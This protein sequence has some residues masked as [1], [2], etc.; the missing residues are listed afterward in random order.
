MHRETLHALVRELVS[1]GLVGGV[2]LIVDVTVFNILRTT[3]F[4][5][6]LVHCGPVLAKMVSTSLAIAVNWVGNRFWTF[7]AK[8]R[9]GVVREGLEFAV[10]SIAGLIVSVV[11]LWFSHYVLGLTSLL[12]DNISS[13]IVGLGLGTLVRF[14]LYRFWV[15]GRPAA[16]RASVSTVPEKVDAGL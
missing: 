12:D 6:G 9:D 13:N 10:A 14:V 1:F 4:A 15:W 5:P 3:V 11:C 8:R 16:Q 2:G 7:R